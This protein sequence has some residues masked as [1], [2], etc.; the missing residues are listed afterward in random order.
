M[1]K[2]FDRNNNNYFTISDSDI[3]NTETENTFLF[4]TLTTSLDFDILHLI[5]TNNKCSI[6]GT[7]YKYKYFIYGREIS[8]V[9]NSLL[10]TLG[11]QLLKEDL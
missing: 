1:I 11:I 8:K 6:D 5:Q 10:Y 2:F 9:H 7:V 4:M 3:T